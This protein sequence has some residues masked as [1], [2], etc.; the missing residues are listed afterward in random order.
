MDEPGSLEALQLLHKDLLALSESSLPLLE[1]LAV[2]LQNHVEEFQ[3]LLDIPKRN[4]DSRQKLSTGRWHQ[5]LDL[6]AAN[7]NLQES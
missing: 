3:K 7:R 2:Q 6:N 5:I 4:N 1:R